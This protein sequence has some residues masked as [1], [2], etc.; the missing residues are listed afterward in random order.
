ML[1]ESTSPYKSSNLQT[2]LQKAHNEAIPSEKD[3]PTILYIKSDS[4]DDQA[5]NYGQNEEELKDG[6]DG[7]Q[8]E[9]GSEKPNDLSSSNVE[10][11]DMRLLI[12]RDARD[13]TTDVIGQGSMI[14][15]KT[16]LYQKTLGLSQGASNITYGEMKEQVK[17]FRDLIARVLHRYREIDMKEYS[18]FT[19]LQLKSKKVER[20]FHEYY[21]L[22]NDFAECA[23]TFIMNSYDEN[24]ISRLFQAFYLE[25]DSNGDFKMQ[26]DELEQCVEFL[27]RENFIGKVKMVETLKELGVNCENKFSFFQEGAAAKKV[28][29]EETR[30]KLFQKLKAPDADKKKDATEEYVDFVAFAPYVIIFFFEYVVKLFLNKR[31]IYQSHL[32]FPYRFDEKNGEMHIIHDGEPGGLYRI[33]IAQLKGENDTKKPLLTYRIVSKALIAYR[34]SGFSDSFTMD[35]VERILKRVKEMMGVDPVSGLEKRKFTMEEL[36]PFLAA[37]ISTETTWVTGKFRKSIEKYDHMVNW[38]GGALCS[39]LRKEKLDCMIK[40]AFLYLRE[41]T[42]EQFVKGFDFVLKRLIPTLD[43]PAAIFITK[44]ILKTPD[45]VIHESGLNDSFSSKIRIDV[46]YLLNHD[47]LF[48][49]LYYFSMNFKIKLMLVR[50]L[51][52][53]HYSYY[54]KIN[55]INRGIHEYNEIIQKDLFEEPP[56][57]LGMFEDPSSKMLKNDDAEELKREEE[58]RNEMKKKK[59]LESLMDRDISHNRK[60]SVRKTTNFNRVSMKNYEKSEFLKNKRLD[61]EH[62]MKLKAT[63]NKIDTEIYELNLEREKIL[64]ATHES[65]AFPNNPDISPEALLTLV[66]SSDNKT[67]LMKNLATFIYT[68]KERLTYQ[69]IFKFLTIEELKSQMKGEEEMIVSKAKTTYVIKDKPDEEYE[70]E[71]GDIE[72]FSEYMIKSSMLSDIQDP[73]SDDINMKKLLSDMRIKPHVTEKKLKFQKPKG[74]KPELKSRDRDKNRG[75]ECVIN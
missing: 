14:R 51:H 26:I 35:A 44:K 48:I 69:D 20:V 72:A 53:N 32:G 33:F 73:G 25:F 8:L 70:N 66:Q 65:N 22:S 54:K 9:E 68:E 37:R 16:N 29:N 41:P 4:Q 49:R 60:K 13:E 17:Q 42:F 67:D 74:L 11:L 58:M 34:S 64:K 15:R 38:M 62:Q 57:K 71:E 30:N 1:D 23:L 18:R 39:E 28:L 10:D 59:F 36:L 6:P 46:N 21:L 43:S 7:E 56:G 3:S 52:K 63:A 5:D 31:A 61:K 24:G 27:G 19:N 40:D 12:R 55:K 50:L 2:S 45:A 47:N 75:C